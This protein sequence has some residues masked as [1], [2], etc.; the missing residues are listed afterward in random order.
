M[1][2]FRARK[3]AIFLFALTLFPF[4][5]DAFPADAHLPKSSGM[6]LRGGQSSGYLSPGRELPDVTGAKSARGLDFVREEI[7]TLRKERQAPADFGKYVGRIP[8]GSSR[9]EAR[10]APEPYPVVIPREPYPV[11]RKEPYPVV[12]PR[13]GGV[14]QKARAG[15]VRA[16]DP[17]APAE[18]SMLLPEGTDAPHDAPPVEAVPQDLFHAAEDPYL[19]RKDVSAIPFSMKKDEKAVV[20]FCPGNH[21]SMELWRDIRKNRDVRALMSE[22]RIR[23]EQPVWTSGDLPGAM[24]YNWLSQE[25]PD[26]ALAF[27]DYEASL[28]EGWTNMENAGYLDE[29]ERKKHAHRHFSDME[30]WLSENGVDPEPVFED[31]GVQMRVAKKMN[32]VNEMFAKIAKDIDRHPAVF[33]NG[34]RKEDYFESLRSLPMH[35]R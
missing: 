17:E 29:K 23:V 15:A 28:P 2:I 21:D 35:Q 18:R 7:R 33:V 20:Y 26:L 8:P 34:K 31:R 6:V 1:I 12:I 11:T 32:A 14:S 30:T 10:P 19:V 4:S 25:N 22:G 13:T 27:L 24:I 16:I 9:K 5:G 3:I